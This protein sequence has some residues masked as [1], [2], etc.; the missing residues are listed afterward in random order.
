[1]A[2]RPERP[3]GLRW[4]TVRH[5][6][7]SHT[8]PVTDALFASVWASCGCSATVLPDGCVDV[9]WVH[10]EVVVAGAATGAMQVSAS[11]E[12][13]PFG[14]RLRTGAVEAAPGVPADVIRDLDVPLAE[15]HGSAVGTRVRARVARARRSGTRAAMRVLAEEVDT[16][17]VNGQPDLL[18][19]EAH[20]RL[21]S[22]EGRLSQVARD[23]AI[24]ERQLRRRFARSVGYGPRTLGRVHR[25]QQILALRE[26]APGTSLADLSSTAGYA[27]QAHMTREVR[28]LTGL[29]P[30]QLLASGAR[31]AGE[32]AETF[33]TCGRGEHSLLL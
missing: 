5:A 25:V 31:A 16:L 11:P 28:D 23:L 8:G 3:L 30:R 32:K 9:V 29:T 27:D 10:G 26:Q 17:A 19:R 15:L 33:K 18:V 2:R 22:H 14:V 12:G 1:M 24:S 20:R 6:L 21:V 4:G 13:Q 7:L